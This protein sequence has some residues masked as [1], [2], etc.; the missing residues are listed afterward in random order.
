[1]VYIRCN[2]LRMGY[3]EFRN[4]MSK[5]NVEPVDWYKYAFFVD[6]YN[7]SKTIEYMLGYFY[8]QSLSSM[9][10]VFLLNPLPNDVLLDLC[11]APGSKATQAAMHMQNKGILVANDA[12]YMRLKSLV[13]HIDRLGITNIVVTNYDGSK[14]PGNMKFTKVLVDA[15][16]SSLGSRKAVYDYSQNRINSLSR[17]QK[18]LILRGYDLLIDGGTL[19]YS[20]CTTTMEENEMVIEHLLSKRDDAIVENIS[21]PFPSENGISSNSAVDD[22]VRRF[23]LDEKFFVAKIKKGGMHGSV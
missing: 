19:V 12:S 22:F 1:M 10:P 9:V 2:S 15:P 21:L 17:L 7:V 20:T 11:A 23:E 8:V 3:D 16:C 14:F 18:S 6:S 4:R 5:Y 13:S